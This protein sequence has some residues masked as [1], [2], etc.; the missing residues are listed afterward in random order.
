M[1][2]YYRRFVEGFS[3]IASPLTS[4]TCKGVNYVWDEK[5]E[6]SFQELKDQLTSAPVLSLPISRQEFVVFSDASRHG[7]GLCFDVE[8]E[9]DSLCFPVTK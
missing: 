4:L 3:L 1:A 7:L 9:G 5:S 8:W 6:K 2:G